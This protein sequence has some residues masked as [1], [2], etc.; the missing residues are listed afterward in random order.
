MKITTLEYLHDTYKFESTWNIIT[1]WEN[2][3]WEYIILDSTIF[4]PQGWW[5]PTD[6][7]SIKL[8]SGEFEVTNVRLDR[9]WIVYHYGTFT[10]P[11]MKNA[12]TES[13]WVSV[14]LFVDWENRIIN[15]KNHTAG[16]L[17]DIAIKNIWLELTP[18]KGYHFKEWSY[19]QYAWKIEGLDEWNN[20]VDLITKLTTEA[21]RL[22]QEG[23]SITV[24]MWD[25]ETLESWEAPVWKSY[26][27]VYI[28]WYKAHWCGCGGTHVNNTSEIWEIIIRKI[29]TKKWDTQVSYTLV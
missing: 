29:R 2:E 7:W 21:N 22:I 24:D 1:S 18:Q 27:F 6:I 14:Q 25:D 19:V 3:F 20:K 10:S 8:S 23:L 28:D 15:A 26:R 17:L 16:H 13:A 9:E 4:Y 11:D 5:Q 12:I